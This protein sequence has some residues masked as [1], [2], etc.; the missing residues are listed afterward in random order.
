M[1][2]PMLAPCSG[3]NT[4]GCFRSG[5]SE[6]VQNVCSMFAQ[7]LADHSERGGLSEIVKL[8]KG[9]EGKPCACSKSP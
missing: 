7:P 6:L 5:T 3:S 2:Q 9:P 1:K 4:D 8:P